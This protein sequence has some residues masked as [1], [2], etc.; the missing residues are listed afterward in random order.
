MAVVT[1]RLT[2][3]IPIPSAIRRWQAGGMKKGMMCSRRKNIIEIIISVWLRTMGIHLHKFGFLSL[4]FTGANGTKNSEETGD[5]TKN[6]TNDLG[7]TER[8]GTR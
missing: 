3:M 1:I 7:Q 5:A 2:R 8:L 6:N 4:V